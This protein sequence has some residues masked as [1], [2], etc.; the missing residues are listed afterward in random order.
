[1]AFRLRSNEVVV[2]GLRRLARAQLKSTR[3]QLRGAPPTDEAIHEARKCIKKTRVILQLCK[4]DKAAGISRCGKR[5][6]KINRALSKLRDAQAMLETLSALQRRA[7]TANDRAVHE[8]IRRRLVSHKNTTMRAAAA[9]KTWRM[10]DQ[11]CRKLRKAA[12]RWKPKHSRFTALAPGIRRSYRAGRKALARVKRTNR[13]SDFHEWRKQV[14]TLWYELRLLGDADAAL[15][16]QVERLHR[17]EDWLG[18]DHNIVVLCDKLFA[19][20][21]ADTAICR[22]ADK[23]VGSLRRRAIHQGVRAYARKANA[24][25]RSVERGWN[26]SHIRPA[27]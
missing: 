22:R 1:M 5:L 18:D 27:D 21:P 25:A 16:A 15:T 20:S 23:Q 13:S 11:E 7:Q 10:I 6:K 8:R 14:K 2:D 24:F 12:R 9:A 4:A 3:Q 26:A 19:E 17:L